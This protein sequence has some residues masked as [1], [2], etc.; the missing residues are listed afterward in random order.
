VALDTFGATAVFTSRRL[1]MHKLLYIIV[2]GFLAFIFYIIGFIAGQKH[3]V[4]FQR[5]LKEEN[6]E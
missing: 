2:L 6:D 4:K 3:E 1:K 5:K